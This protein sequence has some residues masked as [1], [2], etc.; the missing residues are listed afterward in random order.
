MVT[1]GWL[2]PTGSILT[3]DKAMVGTLAEGEPL[4]GSIDAD[5]VLTGTVTTTNQLTGTLEPI[6]SLDDG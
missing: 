3:V 2:Y 4:T 6:K 1:S 5:E